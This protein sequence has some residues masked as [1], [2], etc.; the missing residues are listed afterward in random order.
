MSREPID[1]MQ[2]DVLRILYD[3]CT[4]ARARG[5]LCAGDKVLVKWPRANVIAAGLPWAVGGSDRKL[6]NS[7]RKLR[8]AG[9]IT[10]AEDRSWKLT[11]KG[12]ALWREKY[13][14][15]VSDPAYSEYVKAKMAGELD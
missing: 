13:G 2:L 1:P 5:V 14:E 7:L 11:E 15:G 9:L 12:E 8:R 4:E 10:G 6:D 3:L